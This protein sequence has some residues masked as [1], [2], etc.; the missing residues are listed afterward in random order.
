MNQR[1]VILT[2]MLSPYRIPLFNCIAEQTPGFHVIFL[3]IRGEGRA[4]N[5]PMD[6]IRFS[7]EVL[8]VPGGFNAGIQKLLRFNPHLLA[9]LRRARPDVL[10]IGGWAYVVMWAALLYAHLFRVRT[11]LWS[12]GTLAHFTRKSQLVNRFRGLFVRA[13][14][15]FVTY[16]SEA[17]AL[18][19]SYGVP[20]EKIVIGFNTGDINFYAPLVRA[21]RQ[22]EE[23]HQMAAGYTRPLFLYVGQFVPGKGL[24]LLLKALSQLEDRPDLVMVG[25]GE[26]KEA[27]ARYCKE[28]KISVKLVD[29][30]QRDNLAKYFAIADA[31]VFPTLRDQGAIVLSEALCS[32]L[33]TLASEF[34]G[35]AR[36]LIDIDETGILISPQ[37][38][39]L[40]KEQI[41][42]VMARWRLQPWDREAI[43]AQFM[44]KQPIERYATAILKSVELASRSSRN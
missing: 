7:Y 27:L 16:G 3:V 24:M 11:V 44:G 10:I 30:Q 36:D 37:D 19:G 1:V 41:A 14:N 20:S 12:G 18:L 38:P 39:A 21:F 40:L 8:P 32:G 5:I 22:T 23:Y 42:Q 17:G 43:A 15:A 13:M 26:E 2:N 25:G 34:D 33:F 6:E 4:W 28:Q 29:F 9:A 31:F 35:I